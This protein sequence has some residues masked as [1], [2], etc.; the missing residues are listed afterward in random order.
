[1]HLELSVQGEMMKHH[2]FM[3]LMSY[4][5]DTNTSTSGMLFKREIL[6]RLNCLVA[7][8]DCGCLFCLFKR[9]HAKDLDILLKKNR[10]PLL[11]RELTANTGSP[12]YRIG[13]ASI[14]S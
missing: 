4:D 9:L 5:I 14:G 10:F 3:T 11:K 8:R 12:P 13:K 6:F 1:M 2:P 7:Y